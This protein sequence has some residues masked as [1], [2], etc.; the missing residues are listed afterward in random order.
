MS[1]RLGIEVDRLAQITFDTTMRVFFPQE[2]ASMGECP[3]LMSQCSW[4]EPKASDDDIEV[5]NDAKG[6]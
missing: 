1:H 3:Y 2:A 4:Q 6:D 5:D